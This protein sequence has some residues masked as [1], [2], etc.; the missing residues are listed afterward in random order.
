MP[1]NGYSGTPQPLAQWLFAP[2][3]DDRTATRA[4]LDALDHP[5]WNNADNR[6]SWGTYLGT[7]PGANKVPA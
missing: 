6:Y 3:L 2:M 5:V 4:E 7:S 1:G